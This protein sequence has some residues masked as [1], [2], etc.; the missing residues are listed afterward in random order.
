[1]SRPSTRHGHPRA[2]ESRQALSASTSGCVSWPGAAAGRQC[3]G[4][5]RCS[6]ARIPDARPRPRGGRWVWVFAR[7]TRRRPA[8]GFREG[9]LAAALTPDEISTLGLRR[10]P[11]LARRRAARGGGNA[12]NGDAA[13]GTR[14]ASRCLTLLGDRPDA[15]EPPRRDVGAALVK[16]AVLVVILR[17]LRLI[18][19]SPRG[20]AGGNRTRVLWR[21]TRSSPGA[22]RDVAFLSP[23]TPTNRLPTGSVRMKS[24]ST[25]LTGVDQQVS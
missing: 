20:G 25:L 1:M 15:P 5:N 4:A 11:P 19:R 12:V 14:Q 8:D 6:R 17:R 23:G 16:R 21:R 2:T 22:V 13:A 24:R 9:V 3:Y 18:L 10:D 7:S